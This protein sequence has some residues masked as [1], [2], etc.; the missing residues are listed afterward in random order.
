MRW[1][2]WVLGEVNLVAVVHD[3]SLSE[4]VDAIAAIGSYYGR[5]VPIGG[6]SG[7]VGDPAHCAK[8]RLR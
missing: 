6:Y 5:D 7:S 8:V 3:A 4:G 1:P 2:T